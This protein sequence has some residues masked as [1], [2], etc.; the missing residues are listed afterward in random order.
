MR[1]SILVTQSDEALEYLASLILPAVALLVVI[2]CGAKSGASAKQEG[3]QTLTLGA[4]DA[5]RGLR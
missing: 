4:Y 2:G 5:A 3:T 1:V